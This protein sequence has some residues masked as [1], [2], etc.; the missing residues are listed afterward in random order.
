MKAH[1]LARKLLECPDFDVNFTRVHISS[2]GDH[3]YTRFDQ[4]EIVDIGYSDQ[5]IIMSGEEA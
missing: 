4:V 3:I 5:I 1:G 2:S